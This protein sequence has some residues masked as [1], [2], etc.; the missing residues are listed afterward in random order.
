MC[1]RDNFGAF[2]EPTIVQL[3]L[4]GTLER[5]NQTNIENLKMLEKVM[6][7]LSYSMAPSRYIR[8]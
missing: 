2:F 7:T 5:R 4:I 1:K 6:A 8:Y 3:P